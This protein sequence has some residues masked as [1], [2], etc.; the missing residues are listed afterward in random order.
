MK[1]NLAYY[2][3]MLGEDK[4]QTIS[5]RQVKPTHLSCF[6]CTQTQVEPREDKYGQ[7]GAAPQGGSVVQ[8]SESLV[9]FSH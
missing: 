6:I 3:V 8:R 7:Y 4:A 5:P 1:D 9:T 2:S